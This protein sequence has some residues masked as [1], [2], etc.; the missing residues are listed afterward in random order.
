MEAG[1][2]EIKEWVFAQAI[3]PEGT[4][5]KRA[6]GG[7]QSAGGRRGLWVIDLVWGWEDGRQ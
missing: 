2:L 5:A 4:K 6:V 1:D 7:W 3:A